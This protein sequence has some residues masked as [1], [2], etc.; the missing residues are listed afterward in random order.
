ME[1]KT[2]LIKVRR[3]AALVP[4]SVDFH[5]LAS[6]VLGKRGFSNVDLIARWPD[7]VG[8]ELAN[9]VRPDKISYPKGKRSDGILYVR[10]QSGSFAMILE[11]RKNLVLDKVNTFLGYKAVSNIKIQQDNQIVLK[12]KN[13]PQKEKKLSE[14]QEKRLKMQVSDILDEDL[15]EIIYQIGKQ[16]FSKDAC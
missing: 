3:Q 2:P 12:P 13:I 1:K 6:N 7:V 9:A 10:V 16:L 14:E 11:H 8:E 15:R 5:R 4:I